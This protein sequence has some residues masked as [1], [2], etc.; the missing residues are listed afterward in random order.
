VTVESEAR[1]AEVERIKGRRRC[2]VGTRKRTKG[3]DEKHSGKR[4]R[5]KAA[6]LLIGIPI[7]FL[8]TNPR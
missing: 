5:G 6:Y 4:L 2:R 1:N 7:E 3:Q 8:M